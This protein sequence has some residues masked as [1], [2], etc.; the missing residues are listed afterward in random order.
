MN[1]IRI[2]ISEEGDESEGIG[3]EGGVWIHVFALAARPMGTESFGT[4]VVQPAWRHAAAVHTSHQSTPSSAPF[5]TEP[6][7]SVPI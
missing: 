5:G 3:S 2:S 6:L 1:K 7:T 4:F